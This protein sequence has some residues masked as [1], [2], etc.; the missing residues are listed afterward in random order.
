MRLLES[1]IKV[2]T[3]KPKFEVADVFREHW[4]AYSLRY[5]TT[6]KERQVAYAIE[7]CRTAAL[8]GYIEQCNECLKLQAHYCSC[9]DRYCPKCGAFE[10]EKWLAKHER[11]ILPVPYYHVIFTIDHA[12]NALVARNKRAIYDLVIH[13]VEDTLK[14]YGKKHLGGVLGVTL[15]LHTWGQN[16]SLHIHVHCLVTGGAWQETKDGGRW[17]ACPKGKL[18]PIIELSADYRDRLCDG[19]LEL[20]RAGML[21]LRGQAEGI[22]VEA[23]VEEIRAKNWEVFAKCVGDDPK[24]V[25]EYLA[26]YIYSMAISNYRIIDISNGKVK[27]T[28]YDNKNGGVK[29]EMELDGVE[30]IRRFLLHILPFRYH[31]VRYLGLHHNRKRK[32]L[33]QCRAFLGLDP[34]IPEARELVLS[35]WV[36][37]FLGKDPRLCPFC[38][39]G[40]MVPY[41]TFEPVSNAKAAILSILGIPARGAVVG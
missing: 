10:R 26:R 35:E 8:G 18:F 11:F 39:E 20:Y 12:I 13:S 16:L 19:L 15:V 30:F 31:R 22:D 14:K 7:N 25:C 5:R 33:E 2:G 9:K 3:I 36:E 38:E 37:S 32:T 34:E 23:M 24:H 21:D 27:F 29:R 4:A 41:R 28:Y 1:F 17:K 40:R 6:K